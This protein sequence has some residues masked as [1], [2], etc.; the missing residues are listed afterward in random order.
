MITGSISGL[1]ICYFSILKSNE[2]RDK[3]SSRMAAARALALRAALAVFFSAGVCAGR[4][5]FRQVRFFT[6]RF[7][8]LLLFPGREAATGLFGMGE[9]A[10]QRNTEY[11]HAG[12]QGHEQRDSKQ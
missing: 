9:M 11:L 3:S 6:T 7:A 4:A 1:V 2:I 12:R 5:G 10:L 8:R